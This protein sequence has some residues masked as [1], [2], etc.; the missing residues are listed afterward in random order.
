MTKSESTSPHEHYPDQ[1][2]TLEDH[3]NFVTTREG[4]L[5]HKQKALRLLGA[6]LSTAGLVLVA[7]GLIDFSLGGKASLFLND[8]AQQVDLSNAPEAL[9]L[10]AQQ[11]QNLAEMP[12]LIKLGGG[13]SM[14]RLGEK[15][16]KSSLD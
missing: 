11:M 5:T 14:M 2:Y 15:T 10:A 16:I 12:L 9:K 7:T 1:E 3:D 6:S 8:L 4:R 13:V